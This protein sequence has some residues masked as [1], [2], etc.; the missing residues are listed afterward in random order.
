MTRLVVSLNKNRYF[1]FFASVKLA[2][3]LMLV[4]LCI[5]A[6]ATIVESRYNS[7][8]ARI[9][10]YDTPWFS[11]LLILLWIN[12]F[13]STLSRYPYKVRHV[14][15][16][17]VH[18]G[19]MTLLIGGFLT[20]FYGVDGQ[21]R[22]IEK[23]RGSTVMLE[24]QSLDLIDVDADSAIQVPFSRGRTRL[25]GSA[26]DFLNDHFNSKILV[27][28][29][30]P[31]AAIHESSTAPVGDALSDG[32]MALAF[33]MKS[34]FF[35]VSESLNSSERPEIKM[36]PAT[37]RL[38]VGKTT[39]QK[40]VSDA[41]STVVHTTP[42]KK[43][44][45]KAIASPAT[46]T[47]LVRDEVTKS[48]LLEIPLPRLKAGLKLPKGAVVES[49]K[50]YSHAVVTANHLLEGDQPG[51]NPALELQLKT[52]D[53]TIREVA[54]AKFPD[55]SLSH[56]KGPSNGLK[57]EYHPD[58]MSPP[59][60]RPSAEVDTETTSQAMNEA[61]T[62]APGSRKGNVIEFHVAQGS[63]GVE[64]LLFKD[65]KLVDKSVLHPGQTVV[66]PWMGMKLTLESLNRSGGPAKTEAVEA[67]VQPRSD[68]PPSAIY[69]TPAGA[70]PDQGFWLAEGQ[71]QTLPIMG[72]KYEV[73]FGRKTLTLPFALELMQ[74]RKVDYPGTETPMSFESS[75]RVDG[76]EPEIV[77]AMNE[78]L[79]QAGYTL[80]QS[81]YDIQPGQPRASIFS[82]NRD[83]GRAVKYL[84]SLILALGII[85]FTLM[86]SRLWRNLNKK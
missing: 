54:Y 22:V 36:G 76:R 24:E 74:F 66:T 12:I 73:Y 47:L 13:L 10:V 15:F 43:T 46:G 26:L 28:E 53:K 57:F 75:V 17:M 20:K 80:Y 64:T 62:G 59:V 58:G 70:A 7:D 68:L 52:G 5:V 39:L 23:G 4:L 27:R 3:P 69:I 9:I 72:R 61:D 50:F 86:R 19:L 67:T 14:G 40:N 41:P 44:P 2:I 1:R 30:L 65:G 8:Y 55:F 29:F 34:A 42:K 60:A 78:P 18:I 37:I 16:V 81:S 45:Q 49:V 71:F 77:V 33:K 83:P 82:V 84:G 35:D 48:I 38:V 85:T 79:K 6:G 21:L 11:A 63:D 25:T 32:P 51:T 31:F 56:G